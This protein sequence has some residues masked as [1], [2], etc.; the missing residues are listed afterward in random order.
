MIVFHG[1][2]NVI[3][4]PEYGKGRLHN[5]YGRGFYCTVYEELAKEWACTENTSGFANRYEIDMS[6]MKVL[7]LS[8]SAY[9]I[10]HWLTVLVS[11]RKFDITAPVAKTGMEYLKDN[12][13]VDVEDYDIVRGYRADDSY[14]S[15]AKAFL[16]NTITLEQ[17]ARAMKLGK[18]GEQIVLKSKAA[19]EAVHFTDSNQAECSVYYSK[20]KQRDD[21][22]REEYREI[23]NHYDVNGIYLIDIVREGIKDGDARL[24]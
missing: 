2:K 15:F 3:E 18:L 5:D 22:A 14:F 10:L 24:R 12:F 7:N 11:Y 20:R 6:D 16:N 23:G 9:H 1:S 8:D 4:K 21:N 19:F 13:Q 17:L